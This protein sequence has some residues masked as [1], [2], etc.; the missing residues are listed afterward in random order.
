MTSECPTADQVITFSD[1]MMF[2]LAMA[3]VAVVMLTIFFVGYGVT[4]WFGLFD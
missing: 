4:K 1:V 3:G 2:I